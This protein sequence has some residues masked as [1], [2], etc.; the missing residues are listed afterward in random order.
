MAFILFKSSTITHTR[1]T[2][3]KKKRACLILEMILRSPEKSVPEKLYSEEIE[4][5]I[6]Y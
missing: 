3:K 2:K 4:D 1:K 5:D 6:R